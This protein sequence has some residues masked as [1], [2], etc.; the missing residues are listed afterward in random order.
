MNPS[1]RC[2]GEWWEGHPSSLADPHIISQTVTYM[3]KGS[4]TNRSKGVTECMR[5]GGK[6][7]SQNCHRQ[8][9]PSSFSPPHQLVQWF[10]EIWRAWDF[11]HWIPH[12]PACVYDAWS[13][14]HVSTLSPPAERQARNISGQFLQYAQNNA[15]PYIANSPLAVEGL[16]NLWLWNH[17]QQAANN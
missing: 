3:C 10:W 2:Q 11:G 17:S 14:L 15:A 1:N 13:S 12:I 16:C 4:N 8:R 7:N 9:S 5:K 6:C